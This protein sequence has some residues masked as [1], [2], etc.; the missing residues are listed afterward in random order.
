MKENRLHQFGPDNLTPLFREHRLAGEM[1]PAET[2][3]PES[4]DKKRREEEKEQ[5]AETK[6]LKALEG[7]DQKTNLGKFVEFYLEEDAKIQLDEAKKFAQ[8][9][10]TEMKRWGNL[11]IDIPETLFSDNKLV[12]L[13]IRGGLI[14]YDAYLA[15]EKR[16]SPETGTS[17]HPQG[18][19]IG[20][21]RNEDIQDY[22]DMYIEPGNK[23]RISNST[24][25]PVTVDQLVRDLKGGDIRQAWNARDTMQKRMTEL[26]AEIRNYE[27]SAR[28]V[29]RYALTLQRRLRNPTRKTDTA[30]IQQKLKQLEGEFNS[31][32]QTIQNLKAEKMQLFSAVQELDRDRRFRKNYN[33]EDR[34]EI[35]RI[36]QKKLREDLASPQRRR[37][38]EEEARREMEQMTTAQEQAD[39]AWVMKNRHR[40]GAIEGWRRRRDIAAMGTAP[41]QTAGYTYR[42]GGTDRTGYREAGDALSEEAATGKGNKAR[43]YYEGR[44]EGLPFTPYGSSA[45]E[46]EA[47][48][49]TQDELRE[50]YLDTPDL[51]HFV[52]S[53]FPKHAEEYPALD[54]A[55]ARAKTQWGKN[56]G[57]KYGDLAFM[58]S[59]IEFMQREG[60]FDGEMDAR[61]KEL[62][63]GTIHA[64]YKKEIGSPGGRYFSAGEKISITI[65]G[66][67]LPYS[68]GKSITVIYS[69]SEP[70]GVE[71]E[72]QIEALMD[73]GVI[74]KDIPTQTGTYGPPHNRRRV[75]GVDVYFTKEGRYAINGEPLLIGKDGK[76][77]TKE[78]LKG[79]VVAQRE[80]SF[81]SNRP[82]LIH[83]TDEN[84]ETTAFDV[85]LA[86][87]GERILDKDHRFAVTRLSGGGGN[88]FQIEFA[89]KGSFF[90]TGYED[91]SG[92]AIFSFRLSVQKERKEK[93]KEG[94]SEDARTF[95]TFVEQYLNIPQKEL[96]NVMKNEMDGIDYT[97]VETRY[98]LSTFENPAS[99]LL[100]IIG[101]DKTKW[102][103]AQE[104]RRSLDISLTP[105][106]RSKMDNLLSIL[107]LSNAKYAQEIV[108][109]L[110]KKDTPLALPFEED[111]KMIDLELDRSSIAIVSEKLAAQGNFDALPPSEK[112]K[113]IRTAWAELTQARMETID[114]S[115]E[116]DDKGEPKPIDLLI[117][118]TK[119]LGMNVEGKRRLLEPLNSHPS[120]QQNGEIQGKLHEITVEDI[121][122]IDELI[123]KYKEIENAIAK[124]HHLVTFLD[125]HG[126]PNGML[127]P[128]KDG[129]S[130]LEPITKITQH[131][132]S[133]R[134]SLFISSCYGGEHVRLSAKDP[135]ARKFLKGLSTNVD[136]TVNSLVPSEF[137]FSKIPQ[138]Y[139]KDSNGRYNGDLNNDGKVTLGELRIWLDRTAQFNDPR[140]YDVKGNRITRIQRGKGSDLA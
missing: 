113:S 89:E 86:E 20:S 70:L 85:R 25:E 75:K 74:L 65:P 59:Q 17:S 120:Q 3:S 42:T 102:T 135:A 15:A 13:A 81:G 136:N 31:D 122:G 9:L 52:D 43:P 26:N 23:I 8:L 104:I 91:R 35:E 97:A 45:A 39:E 139:E 62:G 28:S 32:E 2:P 105:F 16:V 34:E 127:F 18:R 93:G 14:T 124:D 46:R 107:Y 76:I 108:D 54:R 78:E 82:R 117:I 116:L 114:K 1:P 87:R 33:D 51:E 55:Y 29:K 133:E 137:E 36:G 61:M 49:R 77:D 72:S 88:R 53:E 27:D 111:R 37:I 80:V 50:L 90:V 10:K 84:G 5:E 21:E 40:I 7:S 106:D 92:H 58:R 68:N 4:S 67:L 57:R 129:A 56:P 132:N 118:S 79:P 19:P 125:L 140:S 60:A 98:G 100:G 83:I 94:I 69:P 47:F 71:A 22:T 112:E 99:E 138:A 48:M 126:S 73:A 30:A 66:E 131:I 101:K 109:T 128:F 119:T 130:S 110:E 12:F 41:T 123:S 103:R 95:S 6:I 115:E 134:S 121:G 11:D 64:L 44:S 63:E 96:L 24:G 38:L